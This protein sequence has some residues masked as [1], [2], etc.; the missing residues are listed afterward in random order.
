MTDIPSDIL[1]SEL[2][3]VMRKMQ[4]EWVRNDK[5]MMSVLELYAHD[6][7]KELVYRGDVSGLCESPAIS[8]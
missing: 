2:H 5:K 4:Y 1:L 7:H 6:L 3:R 8:L